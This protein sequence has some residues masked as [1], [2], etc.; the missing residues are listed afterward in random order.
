MCMHAYS[1]SSTEVAAA[2]HSASVAK[3]EA[4]DRT[5]RAR[6]YVRPC[7]QNKQGIRTKTVYS[8]K[9]Y[10]RYMWTQQAMHLQLSKQTDRM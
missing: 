3:T 7:M 10:I 1:L 9:C 8:I 5:V 6:T 2:A 4:I